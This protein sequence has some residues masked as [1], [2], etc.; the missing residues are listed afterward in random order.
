MRMPHVKVL[1]GAAAAALLTS[2]LLASTPATA[3]QLSPA[4]C[5]VLAPFQIR[6]FAFLPFAPGSPGVPMLRRTINRTV[7]PD[8][9]CNDGSAAVM[10]IRPGN[11]TVGPLVPPPSNNWLI[12]FDGGGGCR[13]A[14]S[15]LL[16]RWCGGGGQIFDQAGKM[17]ARGAP[18]AIHE[19]PGIWMRTPPPGAP[20]NHFAGWNQVLVHY[21]SS[22]NW[23][24]SAQHRGLS[25]STGVNFDIRF[26]GE[27]IVNAVIQTLL[28]GPTTVD[29][30]TRRFYG[31][32]LPN[33]ALASQ[34]LIGGESAGTGI[35]NHLDRI[36]E[37]L[38]AIN[39]AIDVRGVLDAGFTPQWHESN[40][41]WSDSF[42]PGDFK[43]YLLKAVEPTA[44]T[45]RG[46]NNSSMDQSC[47]DPIWQAAHESLVTS[48][49]AVL[50]VGS[51]PQVCHDNGY[52]RF[53]HVV[54]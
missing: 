6:P 8:A 3:Q 30:G 24:G 19:V 21:C 4:L 13:D 17:S 10:Y 37:Q 9:V 52:S 45:F 26:E 48:D 33:L 2:A 18:L 38:V 12:F 32:A 47:L 46:T 22:D 27:A 51:H 50:T 25:T 31:I 39:P 42:S 40:I 41:D 35:I 14:D 34:V 49:P 1:K 29:P 20:A 43:D 11:A 53:N 15:C 54:T 5:P 7:Y 36:R 23:T 44:R 16:D 28:A